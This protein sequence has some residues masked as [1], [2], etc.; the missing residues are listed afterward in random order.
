L[1]LYEG[2]FLLD[3]SRCSENFQAATGEV[4]SILE[5][6]QARVFTAEKWDER[7]LAYPIAGRRRAVYYLVRFTA[8]SDALRTIEREV[9][10]NDTILRVLIVRDT[11]AEK[12]HKKGL[13]DL[14]QPKPGQPPEAAQPAEAPAA[15]PGAAQPQQP[16]PA[17]QPP[18]ATPQQPGGT[19]AAAAPPQ[20]ASGEAT[21]APAPAAP[22]SA[23]T[24][25]APDA[26]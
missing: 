14:E 7:K 10:L 21:S 23:D 22:D 26:K 5:K 12:L 18:Q 24:P 4:H 3:D 11:H 1:R 15:A 16:A 2:M 8:P 9:Q 25:N 13:L 19:P 6:N 17:D 20:E